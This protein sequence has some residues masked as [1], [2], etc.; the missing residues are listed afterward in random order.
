MKKVSI[1]LATMI[2]G[3]VFMATNKNEDAKLEESLRGVW[4]LKHQT[5]YESNMVT[6][7]MYNLNGYRQVKMYSK[8]HIRRAL[9]VDSVI[10]NKNSTTFNYK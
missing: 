2:C 7:T 8:G 10:N 9:L 1:L 4:E 5:F 6:D 3:A